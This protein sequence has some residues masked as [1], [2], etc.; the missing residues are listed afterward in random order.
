MANVNTKKAGNPNI[1]M[2]LLKGRTLLILVVLIVF[3]SIATPNFFTINTGL[4]VAKHVA[5]YGIMGIGMTYV[6][7]T[8]GIDL[9]V[10]AV[11]GLSGMIAGGLINEGLTLKMF[12]VT[13][14]FGVPWIILF[15]ALTGVLIG[16]LNGIIITRFNVA[17]FITTLGTMNIARGIAN[18]R[19]G[20]ATFSNITGNKALGNTG[21]DMLGKSVFGV[22]AGV[23]ILVIIAIVSAFLLKKTSFGWHILAIGG[24]TKAAKLSGIKVNKDIT[25]VYMFSGFCSAIVGMISAA[26]LVAAH[27]ATG[28]GWEMNAISAAVLGGT[29]MA[30]GVGSVGGTII[31]AFIIGVINDGM[32]MCGVSEF[33]QKVIKGIVVIVAVIVDQFQRNLQAKMALQ[34]RNEGK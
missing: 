27:P 22:P 7:I 10:G 4:T 24:N 3:F 25:L 33:W 8:G 1:L 14:Y 11:A 9:S 32:T 30:G 16:L 5:L 31:G 15:G 2:T 13:L 17:P 19:S 34:A 18:L 20:G 26:Q 28:E 21:F 23:I 12:G 29:S 6:I